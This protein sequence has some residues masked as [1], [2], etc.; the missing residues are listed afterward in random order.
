MAPAIAC[1]MRAR[2]VGRSLR[3]LGRAASAAPSAPAAAPAP[4][5]RTLDI[6]ARDRAVRRQCP[7][8]TR[9]RRRSS[10]RALAQ[11]AT[12]AAG[13]VAAL[14]GQAGGR[15]R[16]RRRR[17]RPSPRMSASTVPT[18]TFSPG[19]TRISVQDAVLEDLDLDGALLGVDDGD[20]VAA[21]A[22]RRPAASA[23]RRA[24]PPPCRRRARACGTQPRAASRRARP[25]R[26]LRPAAPRH[27]RGASG[28]GSALRRCRRAPP[29]HRGRRTRSR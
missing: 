3:R 10:R 22:P 17:P 29:A 8:P 6:G 11:P 21:R 23:T 7:A 13:D 9:G 26:C 5:R 15:R 12:R 18:G 19:W 16:S 25:R 2:P 28:R 4:R 14:A 1:R 24:C 27:P 20:D